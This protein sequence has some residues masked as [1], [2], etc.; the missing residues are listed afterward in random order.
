[1]GSISALIERYLKDMLAGSES[2][3]IEI[4]R[5][6]LAV[7]F[8]C[9]P[10]QINY[11]LSTRFSIER[12]YIVESRRGGG[13]YVRIKKVPFSEE[14]NVIQEICSFVGNAIAEQP[15]RGIIDRLGSEGV[16]S[17]REAAIIKT[18]ISRQV[19]L[20][21]LPARDQLR[22]NILKNILITVLKDC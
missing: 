9:V 20:L 6:E 10:S 21:G 22:A 12:G 14:L 5:N 17:D 4:Q 19:L 18:A 15:A 1:M 11:V 8:S 3:H 2:G 7:K 13:G 16:L